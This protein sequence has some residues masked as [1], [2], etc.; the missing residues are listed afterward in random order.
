MSWQDVLSMSCF[1]LIFCG[2]SRCLIFVHIFMAKVHAYILMDLILC[3]G[4]CEQSSYQ[5]RIDSWLF[6]F[7]NCSLCGSSDS[8]S[9]PFLF[10]PPIY[11][12]TFV[13]ESIKDQMGVLCSSP[14]TD[15]YPS[16]YMSCFQGLFFCSQV[17][18]LL[19][20]NVCIYHITPQCHELGAAPIPSDVHELYVDKLAYQL[21]DV[22]DFF[23]LGSVMCMGVTAGAYML[24]FF[25]VRVCT[26][27][28]CLQ[29]CTPH[30]WLNILLKVVANLGLCVSVYGILAVDS[31]F[32]DRAARR[33]KS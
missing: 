11:G 21:A 25:A 8:H 7:L 15:L 4:P 28:S 29:I 17:A 10:V 5:V 14:D 33:I 2:S 1:I 26:I 9:V 18:F 27:S 22:L 24:I 32:Q 30:V 31:S 20:H 3:Y 12:L 6:L 19:L 13:R 16:L 23:S